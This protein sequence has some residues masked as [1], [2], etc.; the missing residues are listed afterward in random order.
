[1]DESEPPG[2]ETQA[3]GWLIASVPILV[4]LGFAFLAMHFVA[5]TWGVVYL[6]FGWVGVGAVCGFI[7]GVCSSMNPFLIWKYTRFGLLPGSVAGI[8]AA[9]IFSTLGYEEDVVKKEKLAQEATQAM[10]ALESAVRKAADQ[11]ALPLGRLPEGISSFC[12]GANHKDKG[13]TIELLTTLCG[14]ANPSVRGVSVIAISEI[15]D[16][17]VHAVIL[18]RTKDDAPLVRASSAFALSNARPFLDDIAAALLGLLKDR[19]DEVRVSAALAV[20][21]AMP[22]LDE[23]WQAIESELPKM[24][25]RVRAIVAPALHRELDEVRRVETVLEQQAE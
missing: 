12:S 7:L 14:G 22:L 3:T 24:D 20:R 8:I 10:L 13:R 25:P 18:A 4:V 16:R 19:D 9:G 23:N 15:E 17:S 11:H 21:E 6:I 5:T 1:M 2:P